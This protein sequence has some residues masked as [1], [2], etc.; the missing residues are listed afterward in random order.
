MPENLPIC[1]L[2][3]KSE[4]KYWGKCTD[5]EYHSTKDEYNFYECQNCKLLQIDPM[6]VD[7]LSIIYPSNYYS[8]VANK[9]T[10]VDNIKEWLDKRLFRKILAGLKGDIKILDVGGGSGWLLNVI[11]SISDKVVFTQVVDLDKDAEKLAK[12]NGHEY[13]CGKIEDFKTPQKFDFVLL[14]NLIEH[15]ENPLAVL[16]NI[17]SILSDQGVILIKTPN[18]D[19]LDAR[20]FERWGGLH[21]PRHWVLFSEQS[22]RKVAEKAGLKIKSLSYTQGAPFWTISVLAY[23]HKKKWTKL[24]A[25][26]PIV[27]HPLYPLFLGLFAGFDIL[28]KPFAKTSQMFIVLS[29]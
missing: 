8:F 23:M 26:R 14:L 16:K 11:K 19:S 10:A 4:F 28:R 6:P 3:G 5:V 24:S 9:K 25:E 2:C 12:E 22:F 27:Q 18:Y 17:E 15:V 29:K 7:K 1:T 13:F 21:C 20:M